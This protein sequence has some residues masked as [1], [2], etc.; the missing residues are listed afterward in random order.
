MAFPPDFF[1]RWGILLRWHFMLL[2]AGLP[3]CGNAEQEKMRVSVEGGAT[4][5]GW[6]LAEK[7][8]HW[9]LDV[10]YT[11][12]VVPKAQITAVQR[13]KPRKEE[14]D[15]TDTQE[16]EKTALTNGLFFE[17]HSP[18]RTKSLEE[19]SAQLGNAVVQVQTPA[20]VGS[21]FIIHPEGYCV[22]NFHVIESETNIR[23]RV[24]QGKDESINRKPYERCRIV[25]L[26][27]HSDLALIKMERP[28]N[29]SESFPYVLLGNAKT[30][31]AG[32]A[33]F[34][35][36]SPRGLDRTVTQGIISARSRVMQGRLFLQTT[37]PINPGNSGG[38]LFNIR[39]EVI[40][41]TNMKLNFSEGLGFAIP[42]DRLKTF[43][44]NREAYAYD[45]Q[46][47]SSPHRYLP[48]P[49]DMKAG[50]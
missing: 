10:G 37:T 49:R 15:Q 34:A 35:I 28:E 23:V 32:Q 11:V 18:P 50:N 7:P 21:G 6:L 31:T 19:L 40:G 38:P 13:N 5:T 1:N 17:A 9:I 22:T 14:A 27:K 12:L 20:G 48:A 46:N 2:L 47:P 24:Y 33:S 25:A 26:D 43:L 42:V 29:S 3:F 16:E 44:A 45:T 4:L 8:E 30:I 36:G 39:G 41:V